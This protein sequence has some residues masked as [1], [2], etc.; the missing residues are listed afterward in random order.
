MMGTSTDRLARGGLRPRPPP[1]LHPSLDLDRLPR[2]GGS[3]GCPS[4]RHPL[5]KSVLDSRDYAV[6]RMLSWRNS[7][8]RS[9]PFGQ[10]SV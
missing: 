8:A 4:R 9:A 5:E 2:R 6:T 7:G 3:R 10:T 1:S